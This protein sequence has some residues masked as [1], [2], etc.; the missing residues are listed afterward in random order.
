MGRKSHSRTLS[1]WANGERVGRWTIPT[2]GEAELV[3]DSSWQTSEVGRPIS[4][5]LPFVEG[6]V[7]RGERVVNYFD[8]LLP[9]SE[10]IR[11]RLTTH[12]KIPNDT[13]DL[14]GAIGR[15]CVGAVQILG[16]NDAPKDVHTIQG[17]PLYEEDVEKLL[18][19]TTS[20]LP[21]GGPDEEELRI[22]LA[23]AQEKTALLWD[24]SAWLRPHD[25]TPTT[26]IL[27]LPLGFIGARKA[28]FATSVENEWLCLNLLAEF[29]LPVPRTA[30]VRFG[31][32]KALA[33]ERFDRQM[34]PSR[35]WILRLLQ[36]DFCQ[37]MGLPSWK[38]YE[39][40]GGPG[41]TDLTRILQNSVNAAE[42]LTNLLKAE[43]LFW[44]L[45]APDGHAKNFSLKVL[46]QGHYQLTPIYDVM[47]LWPVEGTA[48]SQI[49]R[50]KAKL[51]MAMRGKNKHYHFNEVKRRHFNEMACK[52]FAR[53][54]AE[55]V[56]R[57]VLERTPTAIENVARRLPEGF[58]GQ[59]VERIFSG[60]QESANEMG[61]MSEA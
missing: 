40:D 42:D 37:A 34:H 2:R 33:V 29:G 50:H 45:L 11:K 23:G 9:D 39:A 12:F 28:D 26:H 58:P 44:L 7:I 60:L 30:I 19:Q 35:K 43:L 59:V 55:D 22:S 41:L 27:K 15:D 32:Q 56:I 5:S 53:S 47:S 31:S 10:P 3:Y 6:G 57:E 49:T 36:E 21:L 17:A 16:E 52:Y 51:A 54:S 1:I 25:A 38:K 13:F 48:A 46:P 14:L 18:R 24:G 4:L 20:S 61:N 8:N